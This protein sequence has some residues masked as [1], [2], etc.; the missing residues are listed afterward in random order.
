MA[1]YGLLSTGFAV[2][3]QAAILDDMQNS[4]LVLVSTNL[5][6][7]P[8]ALMGVLNGIVSGSLSELWQLAGALYNGMDPDNAVDEQLTSLALITG[9]VR[10]GAT[11]T[12]VVCTVNV[13]PF[14][15][16]APGAM[17][18]R[19]VNN[20][21]ALFENTTTVSNPTASPVNATVTFA[22]TTNGPVQVLAGTL[23]IISV[24]LTGWNSITN[25]TDGT[26]GQNEESNSALRIRRNL[27][28]ENAGS[29]TADS[30]RSDVLEKAQPG[31]TAGVTYVTLSCSVLHNDTDTTDANGIPPHSVEVV[32]YAPPSTNFSDPNNLAL[33]Q[34]ILDSK[35]AGIG[36]SGFAA[37]VVVDSQ[38]TEETIRFTRP[39]VDNPVIVIDVLVNPAVPLPSDWD[40]QIKEVLIAYGNSIYVPGSTI[41]PRALE[42]SIFDQA[43]WLLAG[44]SVNLSFILD[45]NVFTVEGGTIPVPYSFRHIPVVDSGS[46]TV[47]HTP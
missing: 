24:A 39:I 29:S 46:I 22:C 18:A 36:T 8:T 4:E 33:A 15:S 13:G 32:A 6:F 47:T 42:S 1:N 38:G 9:T 19:A 45:I 30:I 12:E 26:P 34:I 17:I 28:L 7:Q 43:Y 11:P 5:D 35:A 23:T 40:T 41:Y 44:S 31:V 3:P 25:A 20:T 14:F 2:K 16:A 21:E 27:D 10:E 37:E